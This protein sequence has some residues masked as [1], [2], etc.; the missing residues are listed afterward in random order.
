MRLVR[1]ALDGTGARH[2]IIARLRDSVGRFFDIFRHF[3]TFFDIFRHELSFKMSFRVEFHPF[4]WV[5]IIII[6][7]IIIIIG[8]SGRARS[9]VGPRHASINN[10][11]INGTESKP[12]AQ[13]FNSTRF[14]YRYQR[15]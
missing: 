10:E 3:S 2:T 12:N 14:R 7:I 6:I 5:G 11:L 13:Q 15:E 4:F 1:R 9:G 8:K